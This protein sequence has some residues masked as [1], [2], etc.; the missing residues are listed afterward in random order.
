MPGRVEHHPAILLR[1]VRAGD[2][3]GP[4]ASPSSPADPHARRPA[5]RP[6]GSVSSRTG[7][8]CWCRSIRSCRRSTASCG[9]AR[10]FRYGNSARQFDKISTF[11][12][13]WLALSS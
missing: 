2:A 12:H 10:C 8:G 3:P 13:A 1:L 4:G 5:R 6:T 7:P 9:W 11:A